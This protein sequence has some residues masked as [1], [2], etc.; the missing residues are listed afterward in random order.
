MPKRIKWKKDIAD[1]RVLSPA[2]SPSVSPSPGGGGHHQHGRHGRPYGRLG[3]GGAGAALGPAVISPSSAARS[4]RMDEL[5]A[6]LRQAGDWIEMQV[7]AHRLFLQQRARF[8]LIM[9]H[10]QQQ[11][12]PPQQQHYR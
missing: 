11:P 4:S 9:E 1:V 8:D 6:A 3:L 10:Q 5:G 7:E 12:P 2:P